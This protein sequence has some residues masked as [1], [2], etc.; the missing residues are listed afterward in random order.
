MSELGGSGFTS[1]AV[2]AGFNEAVQKELAAITDPDLRQW[3]SLLVGAAAAKT[4]GGDAQAG[5]STA[6][7]GT[8]NN[9]FFIPAAVKALGDALPLIAGTY[10]VTTP[11]GKKIVDESGKVIGSLVS[12]A[13][14]WVD[15]AGK[16]I[17]NSISDVKDWAYDRYR[18]STISDAVEQGVPTDNHSISDGRSLPRTGEPNSSV[19]LLNP[20]GS[21]KQR[22]YYD[23]DGNAYGDIDYNH[24]NGDES[25]TFPHRHKWKDGERQATED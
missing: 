25:H 15:S 11:E 18:S 5:G 12:T 6:A 7:S 8:K 23:K 24:T 3:A 10:L 16:L 14:G 13:A 20:D 17:G 19:D 1:G 2:G 22:R 9:W 4:V 21:V